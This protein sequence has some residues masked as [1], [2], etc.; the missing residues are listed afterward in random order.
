MNEIKLFIMQPRP[1]C[2]HSFNKKCFSEKRWLKMMGKIP[3]L[4]NL[5]WAKFL[6]GIVLIGMV[7]D[8]H[9]S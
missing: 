5:Q 7:P 1:P 8:G 3:P 4:K 9:S 6:V 2:R